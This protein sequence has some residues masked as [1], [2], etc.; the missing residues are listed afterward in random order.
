MG[1]QQQGRS[2]LFLTT[3]RVRPWAAYPRELHPNSSGYNNN[4]NSNKKRPLT[5][6]RMPPTGDEHAKLKRKKEKKT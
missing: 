4:R 1:H 6:K 3:A 2:G 5:L